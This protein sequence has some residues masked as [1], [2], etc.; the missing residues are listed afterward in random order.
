MGVPPSLS[1]EMDDFS[2]REGG[3]L[4]LPWVRRMTFMT[5]G[6]GEGPSPTETPQHLPVKTC[7]CVPVN[8]T[9]HSERERLLFDIHALSPGCCALTRAN[10]STRGIHTAPGIHSDSTSGPRL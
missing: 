2:V 3:P 4:T 1:G 8:V 10:N 9:T 5:G 6:A 7:C